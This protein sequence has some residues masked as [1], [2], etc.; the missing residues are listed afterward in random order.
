MA[1]RIVFARLGDTAERGV[2]V[3]GNI[4]LEEAD[5]AQEYRA[6]ITVVEN[7]NPIGSRSVVLPAGV[8]RVQ[9]PPGR[10]DATFKDV[11]EISRNTKQR[12]REIVAEYR[13]FDLRGSAMDEYD[14][15][16][17]IDTAGALT[18]QGTTRIRLS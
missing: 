3:T 16:A 11:I 10:I 2:V 6:T 5:M 9:D 12:A 14:V 8:D 17:S 15:N 13:I 1:R 4:K 7:G 18:A